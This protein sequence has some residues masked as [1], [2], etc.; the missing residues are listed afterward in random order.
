MEV[1]ERGEGVQPYC[2]FDFRTFSG[3]LEKFDL[4]KIISTWICRV[5]EEG[6]STITSISTF[7]F[8]QGFLKSDFRKYYTCASKAGPR[9]NDTSIST[10]DLSQGFL[11][12]DFRKYYPHANTGG[13]INVTSILILELSQGFLTFDFGKYCPQ[14]NKEVKN[15][16]YFSKSNF[17]Y[18]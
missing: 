11:K 6:F 5:F 12:F 4:E 2:N 18:L 3:V 8:F 7:E 1:F 10:H 16:L 17:A 14:A 15:H 9:R 13:V